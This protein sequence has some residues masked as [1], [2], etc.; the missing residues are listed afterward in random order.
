MA[1]A[2]FIKWTNLEV[3]WYF[4]PNIKPQAVGE[5]ST[6][7]LPVQLFQTLDFKITDL[8]KIYGSLKS[9][10]R[11]KNWSNNTDF[12]HMFPPNVVGYHFNA[13][14]LQDFIIEKLQKNNRI[15]LN[16]SNITH[17]QIDADYIIDCSGKPNNF[18]DFKMA[19]C[20]PVNSVHV[21]QCYWEGIKFQYTL[22]IARP[23]GWVFGIPLLNRCSIG[24]MYNNKI[25]TL[26]EVKEDVKNIFLE[27]NLTPSETTNTFSFNNYYRKQNYTERV[28]YNGNASF[29]L[30]PLEATSI[31]FMLRNNYRVH[32]IFAEVIDNNFANEMY[33]KEI[34]QI[35]NIIMLHY[36]KNPNFDTEFWKQSH[37]KSKYM[38]DVLRTD[39]EMKKVIE[40]PVSTLMYG[41]WGHFAFQ[42][43][44]KGLEIDL[45]LSSRS[46]KKGVYGLLNG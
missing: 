46:K 33:I 27:F 15:K 22:A 20:I 41:T 31:N 24:Y 9:G 28:C 37:I 25:N 1:A 4:D 43:N 32:D 11:K 8:E 2:H 12:I 17:E 45:S 14:M 38:Y 36:M 3:E 6:A 34:N 10:I 21:T 26:E 18:D 35:Q 30:E 19:E 44:L 42:Q 23:Y 7:D 16:A 29:F 40:T 39:D 5:G 13:V